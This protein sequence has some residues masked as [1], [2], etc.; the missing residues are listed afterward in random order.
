MKC[1]VA[2]LII[3]TALVSSAFADIT[4]QVNHIHTIAADDG[5]GIPSQ[6]VLISQ[7]GEKVNLGP[8]DAN[9]VIPFPQRMVCDRGMKLEVTSGSSWYDNAS[10]LMECKNPE[11]VRLKRIH[12][13]KR[14]PNAYS[15]P[16]IINIAYN[17][18]MASKAN[19]YALTAL[20]YSELAAE[21][22]PFSE[23]LNRLYS[24]R[25]I[26]FFALATD[27]PGLISQGQISQGEWGD[28]H[29]FVRRR[30]A[31]WNIS[32]TGFLD[33]KILS[34]EAGRNIHWFRNH[35]YDDIS[36]VPTN[37]D[38]LLCKKLF[39]PNVDALKN[40]SPVVSDLLQLAMEKEKIGKYG[41][42]TL[43]FNEVHA[44]SFPSKDIA[45]YS[46]RSAF[47]NAGKLLGVTSSVNCDPEQGK[48][49]L[50]R[51]MVEAIEKYQQEMG[52]PPSGKLN[53]KTVRS[54]SEFG[55]GD[56]LSS[57]KP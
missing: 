4:G 41:D 25:S 45:D 12:I 14:Y 18:S 26:G 11:Y 32:D 23:E 50:T 51:S 44:R 10:K 34:L 27:Y 24:S 19:D 35:K 16:T 30:Q 56:Y 7:I 52:I 37:D 8:T 43:L 54:F 13:S 49:V 39:S 57:L 3:Y 36:D 17:I 38:L 9:G 1:L 33:Y 6:V 55:V 15:N 21:F 5:D 2:L 47:L 20:L 40:V 22:S 53:Y 28:F 29:A 42:A 48:Y 46:A 31:D